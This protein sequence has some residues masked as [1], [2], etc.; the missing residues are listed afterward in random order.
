MTATGSSQ[1]VMGPALLSLHLRTLRS[2]TAPV[3]HTI[4]AII[5]SMLRY[6]PRLLIILIILSLITHTYAVSVPKIDIK[7]EGSNNYQRWANQVKSAL[8]IMGLWTLAVNKSRPA[9]KPIYG[10]DPKDSTKTIIIDKDDSAGLKWIRQH[11]M[12][13]YPHD[14]RRRR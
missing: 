4:F 10:A 3:A 5:S 14:S 11:C 1:E 2:L 13:R 12:H 6:N 9:A 7:L 8:V